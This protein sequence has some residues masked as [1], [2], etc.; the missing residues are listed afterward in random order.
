MKFKNCGAQLLSA[1]IRSF[2][3]RYSL[4]LPEDYKSFL[5]STNGGTIKGFYVTP[6]FIETN[7]ETGEKIKQSANVQKMLALE[8]VGKIYDNILDDPVLPVGYLPIANDPFGNNFVICTIV[9]SDY[10]SVWFA[11]HELWDYKTGFWVLSRIC[12]T[13]SDFLASLTIYEE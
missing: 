7:P 10:G 5:L 3:E 8:K 13:F 2:E 1:D 4:S 11:N 9:D 6:E 12:D